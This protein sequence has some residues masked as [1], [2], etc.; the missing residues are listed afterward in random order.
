MSLLKKQLIEPFG[1]IP[2]SYFNAFAIFSDLLE[3]VICSIWVDVSL[4]LNVSDASEYG[5]KSKSI[6]Q[7]Y[8]D[9]KITTGAVKWFVL[10]VKIILW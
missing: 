2:S 7:S 1:L 5:N 6:A 10:N 9:F 4:L 8:I 3:L